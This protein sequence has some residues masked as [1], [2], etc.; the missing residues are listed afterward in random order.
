MVKLT[1]RKIDGFEYRGGV[2]MR[3]DDAIPGFGLRIYDSDKRAFVLRY[4]SP[5]TGKRRVMVLGLYGADLT[6]QQARDEATR[7]RGRI[8]SG[9]D[10]LEEKKADREN[11]DAA[12]L[13]PKVLFRDV[14][15]E[16]VEKHA[17]PRQRTWKETQR[18]LKVN[19]AEWLDRPF[20]SI[21]KTDA[22]ELLDGFVADGHGYKAKRTLS[23][24]RTLWRWAAKRDKVPA[25][26]M[27]AVE[28]EFDETERTRHYDDDEIKAV[29]NATA[30]LE[31]PEGAYV[32]LVI[33]LAPRKSELSGMRR[34]EFD[35][36][37][38]PTLWTVPHERTKARKGQKKKRVYI[39]PLPK[40]AQ[41]I[42]KGLPRLDDDLVFPGA[43]KGKPMVPGT[44]LKARVHE[45]SG[46]ADWSFHPCRDTL[47]TWLED[48][49]H[50]EYE[51]G[52]ILNHS[53]SGGATSAYSHGF[54]VELKRSLLEKWAD[55]VAGVV[56]PE[57]AVLLS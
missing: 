48:Q 16:F 54:P 25:P 23:W 8:K 9:I 3:W 27:D 29:W 56:Q 30:G 57:G 6:L 1:K 33:L 32:K 36:P 52:L 26:L 22:Y 35:D 15:D 55:H 37:D 34:S 40:L 47:T 38:N 24:L 4:Q 44:A 39:V 17:R 53:G 19:C 10:P 51:R 49:G 13:S 2:D 50:N 42:I 14:V 5:V 12:G 41:R 43:R 11:A 7:E 46:V 31:P 21:T 28:I 45:K 18:T 20:N